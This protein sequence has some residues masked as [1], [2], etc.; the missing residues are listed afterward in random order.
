M[1][2]FFAARLHA[3]EKWDLRKCV[4]YARKNN[5]SVKQA[6][7]QARIAALQEQLAVQARYPNASFNTG[8]GTQFGR[9]I[10]RTTNT[11]SNTQS[12]YQ[13]LQ[14]QTGIQVY[15]FDR[16]NNNLAYYRFTAKAALMDVEKSANDAALSVATYFLQVYSAKEQMEVAKVQILQTK[17]QLE[18]TKKKVES[19]TLPELNLLELEAQL[20]NDSTTYISTKVN[21]DQNILALKAVM[22]L[23]ASVPFDVSVPNLPDIPIPGLADLQPEAVYAIALAQQ[24]LQMANK[25]RTIAA[26]KNILVNKA[27]LYPSLSFGANLS[28]NFYNSF[29]KISGYSFNGYAENGDKVQIGNNSYYVQSPNVS[30]QQSKRSFGQ[31]WEGYSKQLENNFGQTLGFSLSVPMFNNGQYRSAYQQSKLAMQSQLLN[32][33]SADQTLKNNIYT[34]YSNVVSALQKKNAG[35]K[36]V[37]INQKAYDFAM[38]RYGL[39]LLGTLDLITNQNNLLKAKLQQVGYE[40]DFIFKIKL[41]EFYKGQGLQL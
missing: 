21:Y 38:K 27:Q 11:Y 31:L 29:N 4:V 1:L 26:E 8:L 10:D 40:Y 17:T 28:S 20:A 16:L 36:S 35:Q 22:N 3:Q 13:S 37:E 34:A 7:V 30:L 2:L 33:E 12:L 6:D 23:D 41:L 15:N 18:L 9:S 24:P 25:F 5:I 19:G 32:K 39:G 14:L